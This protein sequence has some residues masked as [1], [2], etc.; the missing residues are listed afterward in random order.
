MSSTGLQTD[1]IIPVMFEGGC[2]CLGWFLSAKRLLMLKI[3][4]VYWFLCVCVCLCVRSV[5]GV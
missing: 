1:I 5:G 2:L 3:I 4:R